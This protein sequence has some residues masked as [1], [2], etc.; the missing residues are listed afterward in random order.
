MKEALIC[1]M[2]LQRVLK[3]TLTSLECL[4]C[5]RRNVNI[6]CVANQLEMTPYSPVLHRE[7]SPVPY[8]TRQVA[9]LTLGNSRDSL[10]H[11][12]QI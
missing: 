1:L 5:H 6:R 4:L 11:L 2:E 8:H 3:N 12:S 7:Q 10:R 9:C